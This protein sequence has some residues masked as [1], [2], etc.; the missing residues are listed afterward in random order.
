M[1][2]TFLAAII[3]KWLECGGF[4]LELH[5]GRKELFSKIPKNFALLTS[6][7]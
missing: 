5:L 3:G 2:S 7:T 4:S 1:P 6:V